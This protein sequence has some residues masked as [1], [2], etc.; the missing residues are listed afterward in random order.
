MRKAVL[1]VITTPAARRSGPP[2][3]T[4]RV[5]TCFL[6]LGRVA[7]ASDLPRGRLT[8]VKPKPPSTRPRTSQRADVQVA[9]SMSSTHC[10]VG[11]YQR[12]ALW[13]YNFEPPAWRPSCRAIPRPPLFR[14]C[15]AFLQEDVGRPSEWIFAR[16]AAGRPPRRRCD[17]DTP[18]D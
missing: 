11:G 14:W 18:R 8:H 1:T 17:S 4:R 15:A 6:G 5:D 16:P 10:G 9:R 12:D 3:T 7:P 13:R 2:R